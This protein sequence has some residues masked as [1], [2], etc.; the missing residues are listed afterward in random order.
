MDQFTI[1]VDGNVVPKPVVL[2]IVAANKKD[3][4]REARTRYPSKEGYIILDAV[5]VRENVPA[6]KR[7]EQECL[8]Q[9]R[10]MIGMLGEDSYVGAA[11]NGF[12]SIA[13]SNIDDDALIDPSDAMCAMERK[14]T[15]LE[16]AL[17][18]TKTRA[19]S[20]IKENNMLK[21]E[22]KE[23]EACCQQYEEEVDTLREVIADM[24]YDAEQ[25][26]QTPFNALE[27]SDVFQIR[28]V[29]Y[30]QLA[31][32]K[33]LADTSAQAI[34][35]TCEDVEGAVF[36]TARMHY[37]CAMMRVES[38]TTLLNRIEVVCDKLEGTEGL[39]DDD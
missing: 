25:A 24:Y 5:L 29:I 22:S 33:R 12:L 11:L 16:S 38:L 10:A 34:V 39:E 15:D 23:S 37:T 32:E 7:Q 19:V 26:S 14:I 1:T 30:E 17:S 3:A 6:T 13:Q 4:L 35:R 36:R 20:L 9:I 21:Q 8:D 2:N 28:K 31:A 18:S 27:A